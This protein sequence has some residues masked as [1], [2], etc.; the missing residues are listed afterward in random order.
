MSTDYVHGYTPREAYRLVDQATTLTEL[1]HCD[2]TY[3][4]GATVLEAGCGV[5]AQTIT[6]ARQSPDALITSLEISEA[7]LAIARER[8]E[9]EEISNVTFIQGDIFDLPPG[10]GPFDHIFVCFVLE[11]L[12]NPGQAL[13]CLKSVLKPGGT[14]TVIEGDHGSVFF[15]P[16]SS[17]AHLAIDCQIKLQARAGGNACIGRELYPLLDQ[18]GFDGIRVSPR[19]VYVDSSRPELVE[20][21]TKRTFTA[22][23]EGVREQAL[24]QGLISEEEWVRGISDLYRTAEADG[25]F[26]YMF[27]KAVGRKARG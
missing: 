5:G 19:T 27:F 12:P 8:A 16:D 20:G 11:H 13:T 2:T 17:A 21:F 10:L 1:L 4:A 18:A 24:G 14:M 26:C 3:P 23:V 6:L 15:H 7:S 25:T 9:A 22:M